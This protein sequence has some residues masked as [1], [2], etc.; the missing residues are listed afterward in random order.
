MQRQ[1]NMFQMKEQDKTSEKELNKM[2]ISNVSDK[3]FKVT[4][5]KV[6][7]ELRR[8]IDEHSENLTKSLKI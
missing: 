1:R 3:E 2:E 6:L 8:R 4:I 7:N 5:I